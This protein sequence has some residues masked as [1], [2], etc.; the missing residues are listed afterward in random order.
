MP[1]HHSPSDATGRQALRVRK[2]SM[3]ARALLLP[4]LALVLPLAASTSFAAPAEKKLP[5]SPP[6]PMAKRMEAARLLQQGT[7]GATLE[8]ITRVANLG[9]EA[10]LAEQFALPSASYTAYA[11]QLM[12]ENKQGANN[13]PAMGQKFGCPWN[14]NW[15]AFYKQAFE[16]R[17][18]LRQ[19]VANALSQIMVVSLA[20]N[21]LKDAGTAIPSYLDMLGRHA[22]GNF[23]DLL[24]DVTLHP[25]M[26]VYLDMLGSSYEVPNENYA[27][28]L[29]QLFS[30]GTVML[31]EDGSET[32]DAQGKA[33]PTYD[34]DVVLGFSKAFTGW[35]FADQ[36]M[37]RPSK[38]YWPDAKWALPMKP[39]TGRRCPQNGRWPPPPDR[40][41]FQCD[42]KDTFRSWAPPHDTGVKKLLQ[43]AGAPYETLPAGQT[44]E[45]DVEN[46]I[47]N[48]FRHPNVGPFIVKQLI[49]RLVTSNPTPGYVRRVVAVFNDNGKGVRGDMKAVVRA[50]LVDTEARSAEVAAG[51]TFGKLREPVAMFLQLH[52]AF[53]ARSISGYYNVFDVSDPDQLGQAPLKAPSVFNFYDRDFAPAGP[54]GMAGLVAPE[55]DMTTTATVAGFSNFSNRGVFEGY[56]RY[57]KNAVNWIRPN[58]DRYLTGARAPTDD[59][60]AL[61]NELDLL[62]TAGN[63]KAGFK[64]RLVAVLGGVN[65]PAPDEQRWERMRIALWQIVHSPEYAVQ[66]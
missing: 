32:K 63:L 66:R 2:V 48:V 17:D 1:A 27:R 44:P 33:I 26:G 37:D 41:V 18:Q 58:Y 3:L 29:L 15:P 43:Y 10:W 5:A 54:V 14:V 28:E 55:F 9:T 30:I 4:V 56:A 21:R 22:F 20:N 40:P 49:Q 38:F 62:L 39:W 24:K 7:W 13:C 57:G 42:P 16:G 34:E 23:R 25:A 35:H 47:D 31:G 12:A 45:E 46:A 52:R 8:E 36:D 64:D 61:V 6:P 11:E 19:R 50:I 59:P 65:R 53:G 60:R 51:D